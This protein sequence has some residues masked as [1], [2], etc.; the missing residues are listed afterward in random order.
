MSKIGEL[1]EALNDGEKELWGH[2]RTLTRDLTIRLAKNKDARSNNSPEWNIFAKNKSGQDVQ[3]GSAWRKLP[4]SRGLAGEEFLSLTI[5]DPSFEGPMNVAAFTEDGG[6][7]WDIMWRRR[8]DRSE[9]D[10]A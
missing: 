8:Q 6:K 5:D 4:K 7:R 2:I 10:A 3:I 1:E 9:P